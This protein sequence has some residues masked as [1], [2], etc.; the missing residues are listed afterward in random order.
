VK[1]ASSAYV[2]RLLSVQAQISMFAQGNPYDNAKA[3]SC[4][5]TLKHEEV[6]LKQY[7]G[8]EEA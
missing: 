8:F 5:K 6:C 3:E 1:S 4:F 2:E 7:Q